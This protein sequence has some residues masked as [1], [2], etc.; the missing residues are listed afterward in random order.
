MLILLAFG[1]GVAL[2][3]NPA[4]CQEITQI[5]VRFRMP[6]IYLNRLSWQDLVA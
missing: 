6:E 4:L 2:V 5:S 1:M 3:V